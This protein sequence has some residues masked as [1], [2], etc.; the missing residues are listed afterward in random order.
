MIKCGFEAHECWPSTLRKLGDLC[1]LFRWVITATSLAEWRFDTLCVVF[2]QLCKLRGFMQNDVCLEMFATSKD[3]PYYI[4][5]INRDP[6]FCRYV[7]WAQRFAWMADEHRRWSAPCSCLEAERCVGTSVVCGKPSRRLHEAFGA[8]AVFLARVESHER[9]L[10]LDEV[11]GDQALLL[12]ALTRSDATAK[13]KWLSE[14]PYI[15]SL[16][17]RPETAQEILR[18][19]RAS[20]AAAHHLLN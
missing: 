13:T 20:D 12:K 10:N 5:A 1:M 8:N 11:E 19:A 15:F 2:E 14:D 6:H 3:K 9:L 4:E 17:S 16:A 18:Q 7:T